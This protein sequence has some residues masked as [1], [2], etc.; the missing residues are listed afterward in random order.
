MFIHISSRKQSST[1]SRRTNNTI[2][3]RHQRRQTLK[4]V[5][6]YYTN[7]QIVI[8][9][10]N[11]GKFHRSGGPA[12]IIYSD[13]GQIEREAWYKKGKRH[14]SNNAPANVF[15]YDNGSILQEEWYEEGNFHRSNA[16]AYISYFENGQIEKEMWY[17]KGIR[18]RSGGAPAYM[19]YSQK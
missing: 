13:N 1:T 17:K 14:R 2:K 18:Y 3:Y 4:H 9:W 15:Y 5:S 12:F 16:P 19:T 8:S 7:G 11:N 10:F 6:S